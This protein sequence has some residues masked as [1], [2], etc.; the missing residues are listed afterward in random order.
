[1][2]TKGILLVVFSMLLGFALEGGNLM[3]LLQP[4]GVFIICG[5]A[6]GSF[7][8]SN[9]RDL[10]QDVLQGLSDLKKTT[11]YDKQD[12]LELLAFLF[13]FFR[14]R[15]QRSVAD[16]ETQIDDPYNSSIFKKFPGVLANSEAVSFFCDQVRML[17]IG[18]DSIYVF[19]SSME[20]AISSKKAKVDEVSYSLYKLGDSLPA[21]GIIAAVLGVINAMGSIA[22]EPEVLGGKIAAALIGTMFGVFLAYCLVM[23][24]SSFLQKYGHN[25]LYFLECIKV[26]LLAHMQG[27]SPMIA[28]EVARQTIPEKYRPSFAEVEALLDNQNKNPIIGNYYARKFK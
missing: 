5:A 22:S 8:I 10:L 14:I 12:Y 1:M 26:G 25:K 27:S 13:N 9:P 23:P 15:K 20:A 16:I 11:S 3:I 21:I 19:E 4:A 2:L 18:L 7:V 6:L 28:I 17:T 24:I